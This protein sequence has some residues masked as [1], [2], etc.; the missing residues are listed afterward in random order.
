MTLIY[1]YIED[2]GILKQAEFNFSSCRRYHY[3]TEQQI[4]E[5]SENKYPTLKDDF[6]SIDKDHRVIDCISAIIGR[7]AS[8]KTSVAEVL[9]HLVSSPRP[10]TEYAVVWL[11]TDSKG[12]HV[13]KTYS[14]IL[15]N[16][17]S[18]DLDFN[19]RVSHMLPTDQEQAKRSR[20]LENCYK[21][22]NNTESRVLSRTSQSYRDALASFDLFPFIK[23][24]LTKSEQPAPFEVYHS[25]VFRKFDLELIYIS[26]NYTPF[27]G[28]IPAYDGISNLS[29][30]WL[31]KSDSETYRN[32]SARELA[33]LK[34]GDSVS[35]DK[36]ELLRMVRLFQAMTSP[37][38]LEA[39]KKLCIARPTVVLVSL[40]GHEIQNIAQYFQASTMRKEKNDFEHTG[41]AKDFQELI[42][43]IYNHS[44]KWAL[45]FFSAFLGNWM[46]Y[47]VSRQIGSDVWEDEFRSLASE[48]SLKFAPY[49]STAEYE[50]S[51]A[52]YLKAALET[53]SSNALGRFLVKGK[54]FNDASVEPDKHLMNALMLFNY[55]E[56]HSSWQIIDNT[57]YF[58]LRNE[59]LVSDFRYFVEIYF[60]SHTITHFVNFR[61]HPH[62]SAGEYS[63]YFL[64]SRLY[65]LLVVDNSSAVT[66][67][68]G[69]KIDKTPLILF[70]DEIE[71]TIHPDLQRQ[72]ISNVITFLEATF[73]HSEYYRY[74]FHVMF[75]SHS[76]ILLSDIPRTN[77]VFLKRD[78]DVTPPR[79]SALS[80]EEIISKATFGANIHTLYKDSF[81]LGSG[82]IGAFA[83]QTIT[84][85]VEEL[86]GGSCS[87][88]LLNVIKLIDEPLIRTSLEADYFSN[89]RHNRPSNEEQ[90]LLDRLT[91]IRR[92]RGGNNHE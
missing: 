67:M 29:T 55:I 90:M 89:V 85:I 37:S 28:V 88:D 86:N 30:S 51:F 39:T 19:A 73:G 59:T 38:M 53:P 46:K 63:Q 56:Q 9:A 92:N 4:L 50:S 62:L 5:Y 60:L 74:K 20:V 57:I 8:G 43:N 42:L 58:D 65:Q 13:Y 11:S 22:E 77:V 34:T 80:E 48:I 40:D 52:D 36:L 82:L 12:R 33:Q 17:I 76:P 3:D 84:R 72:L 45:R 24:D 35:H 54:T 6:F 87:T 83:L 7:N 75:A 70:F 21:S 69:R 26:N 91:E 49:N 15:I 44:Q 23:S 1:L 66:S 16:R 79:A 61:F 81:F 2:Y 41:Q 71:V 14:N 64:Y 32:P 10:C 31:I 27:G 18:N 25:R 78:S 47:L 68:L